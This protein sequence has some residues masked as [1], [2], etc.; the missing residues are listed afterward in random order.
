LSSFSQA[1]LSAGNCGNYAAKSETMNPR[2][3]S[4]LTSVAIIT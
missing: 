4:R 3:L 2:K 1:L